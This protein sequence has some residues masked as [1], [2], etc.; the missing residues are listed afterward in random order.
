MLDLGIYALQLAQFVF[1]D[2]PT[3]MTV[4]GVLNDDGVDIIDHMILEYSGG[5]RAIL[6]VDITIKLW[7]KATITGT[8]GHATVKEKD[9]YL[10]ILF[11][12][13][14]CPKSKILISPVE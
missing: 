7:N 4:I 10:I 6:N 3:N 13:A 2:E 9:F 1:K 12:Y 5:R 8:K 14:K 11:V